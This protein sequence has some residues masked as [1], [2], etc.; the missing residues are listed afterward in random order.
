MPES[1]TLVRTRVIEIPS[2]GKRAKIPTT[3][4]PLAPED[5]DIRDEEADLLFGLFHIMWK[6]MPRPRTYRIRLV[7]KI[8]SSGKYIGCTLECR[9]QRSIKIECH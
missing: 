6:D 3:F 5:I 4:V 1:K 8:S 7:D 2:S 9:N